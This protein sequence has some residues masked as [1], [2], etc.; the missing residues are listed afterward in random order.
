MIIRKKMVEEVKV[1]GVK[2]TARKYDTYPSNVRR[3]IK[4][5]ENEKST[6]FQMLIF[7]ITM[8]IKLLEPLLTIFV[9]VVDNLYR[10]DSGIIDS[11][12]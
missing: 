11:F 2:P 8:A 12:A 7:Y 4:K 6:L 3:W 10:V 9:A 5:F 1:R